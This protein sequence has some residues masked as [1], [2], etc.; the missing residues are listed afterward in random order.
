MAYKEVQR[1]QIEEV[2]RCWQSGNSH[3]SIATGTGLSWE[4][5]RKYLAAGR[6]VGLVR[7]ES[8]ATEN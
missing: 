5:V 6:K 3:R 2:L 7:E 4:T 8:A 1:A